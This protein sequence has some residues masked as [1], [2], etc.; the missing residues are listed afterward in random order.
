MDF[1]N[2][3]LFMKKVILFFGGA[4]FLVCILI[5]RPVPIVEESRAIVVE[6]IVSSVYEGGENDV[7]LT[8]VGV[9]QRY[10]INRGLE[11]GLVLSELKE[12]LIEKKVTMKYPRYWTPLDWNNEIRHI[13]KLEFNGDVLFNELK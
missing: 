4:F 2:I 3:L 7:V 10:Y 6:G 1:T 5:F 8:L 11:G 9:D 13:S 12:D